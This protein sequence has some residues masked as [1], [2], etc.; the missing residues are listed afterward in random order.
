[1]L[2]ALAERRA[3]RLFVI[4]LANTIYAATVHFF[5]VPGNLV[6][7][8]VTGLALI[9]N[10]FTG[11]PLAVGVL[12]LN[13][14]ML[15][16]G[17]I[18]LGTEFALTTILASFVYPVALGFFERFFP[19]TVITDDILLCTVFTGIGTGIA[20]GLSF[21]MGSSTG[22]LDILPLIIDR[23]FHVPASVG[24]NITDVLVLFSQIFV[25]TTEQFL[26]GIILIIIYTVIIDK[27]M[28][29]GTTQAEIK[30]IS[31]HSDEIR[32]MILKHADRGVT[33]LHGKGGYL[34]QDA[35]I[36]LSIMS[37]REVNKVVKMIQTIDPEAFLT[38]ARINEVKG[39]GFTMD[40]DFT[41]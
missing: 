35:D 2:N 12:I 15:I 8:G 37:N 3:F 18:F 38:I 16:L 20:L 33:I 11:L 36:L 21:R 28:I 32:Q 19:D 5:L 31:K 39:R 1:M 27:L 22:G 41:A 26:Y 7:A 30:V 29:V 17:W 40:K 6:T 25:A 4:I 14:L 24:V 10:H 13:V 23:Y 34:M 9:A